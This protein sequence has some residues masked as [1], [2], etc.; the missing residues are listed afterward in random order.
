VVNDCFKNESNAVVGV[1]LQRLF[2]KF[3]HLVIIEAYIMKKTF[4]ILIFSILI[5]QASVSQSKHLKLEDL[6]H[7]GTF[8]SHTIS[9]LRS[10]ND[11]VHYTVLEDNGTKIVKYAYSSGKKAGVLLDMDDIKRNPEEVKRIVDYEFSPDETKILIYNSV[12]R[13][14]R[15]SFFANYY[16]YDIKYSELLPLAEEGHQQVPVF[17]PN[18]QMIAYVRDNNI[19]LKMLRFG[20]TSAVTDDGQIVKT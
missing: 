11:G 16:V 19:Y 2:K 6:T 17:S 10:M 15:R 7:K 12:E 9:G 18:S 20:T 1:F 4:L 5:A 8:S 13:L 14:Y 3:T